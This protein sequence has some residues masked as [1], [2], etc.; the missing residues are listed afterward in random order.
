M[1]LKYKKL[2][3]Y[4]REVYILAL[5]QE[6]FILNAVIDIYVYGVELDVWRVLHSGCN[7]GRGQS[8]KDFKFWGTYS[9]YAYGCFILGIFNSKTNKLDIL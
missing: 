3:V 5:K 2:I 9:K 8:I 1:Y 6:S 7:L 4:Y